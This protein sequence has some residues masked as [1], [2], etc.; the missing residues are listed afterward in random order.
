VAGNSNLHM[1]KSGRTDEFY[2]QLSTIEEE[3]W[4]YRK[5]FK[6]KKSL[7]S[8]RNKENR[9]IKLINEM[10]LTKLKYLKLYAKRLRR[11]Y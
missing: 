11:R 1:S 2:T 5:Y 7:F 9:L 3:L 4:H 10:F 8:Y 6:D